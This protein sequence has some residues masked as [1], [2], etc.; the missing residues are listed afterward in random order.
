MK[1]KELKGII[2]AMITPFDKDEGLDIQ[3]VK[4]LVRYLMDK[5]V[6]GLFIAGTNGEAHLMNADE[7]VALTRTVVS[8][9]AGRIPVI[10]GAGRCSTW[11]TI[12]LANRLKEAGADY[13]SLVSPSYLVPKQPDLYNH[14]KLISEHVDAPLILYNIP[15]QT[16]L[17][18]APETVEKL[19]QLDNICGIKDSGGNIDIQK[20]YIDI[21]KKY[22]FDVL[23]GSDSLI[24]DT[25]KLGAVASVAATANILPAL[26]VE[27]YEC[28]KMRD[29]EKAQ[30]LRKQMDPLRMNLKKGVAPCIMKKTMNLMGVQ[31]GIPR[32]PIREPKDDIVNDIQRM[33]QDYDF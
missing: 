9:V 1:R 12:K 21:S 2:P 24:L 20:A 26:E 11:E 8:E 28:F 15:S 25:F 27:L 10:S 19:A 29:M 5:G 13:I 3:A 31:V 17:E 33:I 7:V 4:E 32:L 16:K 22:D 14:Y 6:H 30:E 18:I 23:N